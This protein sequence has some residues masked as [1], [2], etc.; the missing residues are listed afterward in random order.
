MTV[1][2]GR[3]HLIWFTNVISGWKLT[4]YFDGM[5]KIFCSA[6]DHQ[7][8][9]WMLLHLLL[10]KNGTYYKIYWM[11]QVQNRLVLLNEIALTWSNKGIWIHDIH[12]QI[13]PR[14]LN[15]W[16]NFLSVLNSINPWMHTHKRQFRPMQS[17]YI[18]E[19]PFFMFS[20]LNSLA[21]GLSISTHFF[22][23]IV[24]YSH[25]PSYTTC[26]A[27]NRQHT[28]VFIVSFNFSIHKRLNEPM[29]GHK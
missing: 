23:L 22:K 11:H 20:F 1:I 12:N 10:P 9:E 25:Y 26:V 14:K 13:H 16:W 4:I 24:G 15:V 5:R 27:I 8:I 7:M 18:K 28:S 17:V 2:N 3:I 19:N 6:C 29:S 21:F